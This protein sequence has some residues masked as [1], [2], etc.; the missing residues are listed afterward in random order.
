MSWTLQ[1]LFLFDLNPQPWPLGDPLILLLLF[2]ILLLTFLTS[3]TVA[4][5]FLRGFSEIAMDRLNRFNLN[6]QSGFPLINRLTD[7]LWGEGQSYGNGI[8]GS[9]EMGEYSDGID[10]WNEADMVQFPKEEPNINPIASTSAST[11]ENGTGE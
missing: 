7:S 1:N 8:T 10:D 4:L 11:D 9:E 6:F 3:S 5:D 2:I